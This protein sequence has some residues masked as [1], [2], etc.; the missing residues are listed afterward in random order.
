MRFHRPVTKLSEDYEL[1]IPA[2]YLIIKD[3]IPGFELNTIRVEG[4][5]HPKTVP[6]GHRYVEP[7][8]MHGEI[9]ISEFDSTIS[10][11]SEEKKKN[12][13][14]SAAQVA[15]PEDTSDFLYNAYS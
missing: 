4:S 2:R 3:D 1:M 14:S 7:L 5:K 8:S 12:K 11:P 13:A 15:E 10:K 9:T 6:V